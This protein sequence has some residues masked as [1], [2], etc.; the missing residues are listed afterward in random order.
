MIWQVLPIVNNLKLKI[1]ETGNLQSFKSRSKYWYLLLLLGLI[2]I[3]MGF[4]VFFTPVSSFV[5]LS[6]FFAFTFL[7][8][9]IFEISYAISNR[10]T[11]DNWGW[12]LVGGI[13]D[14]IIGFILITHPGAS[15][16]FLIF[17]VGFALIF[18][19]IMTIGWSVQLNKMG[20]KNWGWI[21]I[22]GILGLIFSFMLLWNPLFTGLAIVT[23]LGVAFI[24]IGIAQIF[25]SLRL[26][27]LKKMYS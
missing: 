1:M 12:N 6:I 22:L 18:R 5:A 15:M 19:S 26:R 8:S 2:F 13:I 11:T 21:L 7:I 23:Y 16:V 27:K 10:K 24:M 14:L 9:G 17:Y 20:I 4:W 3:A 25:L